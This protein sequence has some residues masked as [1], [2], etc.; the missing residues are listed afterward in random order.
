MG[1]SQY[2]HGGTANQQLD[3]IWPQHEV[4]MGIVG[5]WYYILEVSYI[6]GGMSYIE[7]KSKQIR[8]K[9]KISS[10]SGPLA[11]QLARFRTLN[12]CKRTWFGMLCCWGLWFLFLA[13]N[14]GHIID[15]LC[16]CTHDI[17]KRTKRMGPAL[18]SVWYKQQITC[19]RFGVCFDN[20]RWHHLFL[21]NCLDNQLA[22][23]ANSVGC[24]SWESSFFIL[25]NGFQTVISTTTKFLP[26]KG[27]PAPSVG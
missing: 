11:R 6:V 15:M 26:N 9:Y 22:A 8:R 27:V 25:Q 10:C 14:S 1:L 5:A 4:A 21:W 18:A 23:T 19:I 13:G 12:Q 7:S 3:K 17:Q 2:P 16:C 20:L 24:C